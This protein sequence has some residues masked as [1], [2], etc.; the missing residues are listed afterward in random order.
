[1]VD[2]VGFLVNGLKAFSDRLLFFCNQQKLTGQLNGCDRSLDI[3]AQRSNQLFL[4]P[5]RLRFLKSRLP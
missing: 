3:V 2:L 1:M 5:V 4:A